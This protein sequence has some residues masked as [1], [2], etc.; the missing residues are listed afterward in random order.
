LTT[1]KDVAERAGVSRSAVS[2]TFTEGASV[3]AKTREKVEAAAS[4]LGYRP[5][6]IARSLTTK[7]TKLIGLASN[8]FQNPAFLEVFDNFTRDLQ[9]RG[10]RPLLVN[11]TDDTETERLLRMLRQYNVDA[12]IVATSTLPISLIEDFRIAGIPVVHCFGK[13]GLAARAH[14]VAIDNRLGGRMAAESLALRRY[15]S[16][17]VIGGPQDAVSTRDRLAGFVT[18]AKKRNLEISDIRYAESY[19]YGAGH[20]AMVALMRAGIKAEAI[21]CGDDI[22]GMGA[23]DAARTSGL[24]V[25]DDIG[26]LGF[27]DI[28]M[29]AWDSYSL[30]TIR[31]PIGEMVLKSVELAAASADDPDLAATTEIFDCNVV[32]RNTLR[33]VA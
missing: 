2:R 12:V 4:E 25:P 23:M 22:I 33:R 27:N 16:V 9:S 31:Q 15:A 1:L 26:F 17:A 3:S 30:T 20:D 18:E 24:A 29:A 32:E 13:R 10:Y 14:V 7:R 5:S 28:A 8:N 19:A 6:M 21:F 11:L